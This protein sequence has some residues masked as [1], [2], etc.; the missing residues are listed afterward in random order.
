[1]TLPKIVKKMLRKVKKQD[2]TV[3]LILA[4]LGVYLLYV[5]FKKMRWIVGNNKYLEGNA[6][7]KTMVFFKMDGCG[8]CKNM[9]PEWDKFEKKSSVPTKTMV[10]GK[11]DTEAK[12]W[13]VSGY[14]TI[15]MVQAG[16]VIDT[17]TG[18]RNVAGL[19]GFA[20]KHK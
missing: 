16:K 13:N 20:N 10:A 7:K 2:K 1:M 9:Q 11:N 8:H 5:L 15:L 4:L 3:R 19:S 6:G 12:K 14:P 18:E 17:F